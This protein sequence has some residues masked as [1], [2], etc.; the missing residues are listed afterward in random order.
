[1]AIQFV[2]ATKSKLY[3]RMAVIGPTKS[4]KSFSSLAMMTHLV[5]RVAFIDTEHSRSELYADQFDFDL[6]RLDTYSPQS[7]ID[8]IE[9]AGRAGYQG[10]I[11]DS[12]T[13]AWSGKDG[14]LEKVDKAAE[15]SGNS[16]T[17]WRN[18][19]PLH[20][21]M[22]DAMLSYPGHL[23]ATMR[24]KMD[25]VQEKDAKGKTVIRKIGLQAV[26]RADVEYEFDLIGDIDIDHV[27]TIQGR[28]PWSG[29]EVEKPGAN[30]AEKIKAWLV[31]HDQPE[32]PPALNGLAAPSDT[33]APAPQPEISRWFDF[34]AACATEKKR[35]QVIVNDLAYNTEYYQ[36]LRS[37]G[38]QKSSDVPKREREKQFELVRALR[39]VPSP[40]EA[41]A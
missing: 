22:I 2:K 27:M 31:L 24:S 1:M 14:A 21:R 13:H 41:A 4:G 16:Y 39:A 9:A 7:Y 5:D 15:K 37:L 20:N 36:V 40:Q 11:I 19:T 25:Y 26:Q 3:L 34:L 8:A 17:A 35:L 32:P 28:W 23:I 18:V 38:Y 6:L 12:M 30:V 29:L 10:L 33:L